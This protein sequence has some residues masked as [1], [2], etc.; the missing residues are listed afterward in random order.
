MV[1][2]SDL[3]EEVSIRSVWSSN[4]VGEKNV[5]LH[6]GTF[7]LAVVWDR[8]LKELWLA[9]ATRAVS[10]LVAGRAIFLVQNLNRTMVNIYVNRNGVLTSTYGE[11]LLFFTF[12]SQLFLSLDHPWD[13]FVLAIFAG[14]STAEILWLLR[15]YALRHELFKS[16]FVLIY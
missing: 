15:L 5:N 1:H 8:W 16:V 11:L 10:A 7:R 14:H 12:L 6:T 2:W 9:L 13:G 3:L 4:V